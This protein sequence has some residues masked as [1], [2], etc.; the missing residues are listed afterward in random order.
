M[1]CLV[2]LDMESNTLNSQ[3][4][5]KREWTPVKDLKLVE[6]LV[7]YL[8]EREDK[9]KNK[10]KPRNLKVLEGRISAKLSNAE[11]RAKCWLIG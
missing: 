10:F 9:P 2:F 4:P 6:A 3:G 1:I 11:L 5:F 8:Y 7:E